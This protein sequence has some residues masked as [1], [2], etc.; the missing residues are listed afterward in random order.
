[1][2]ESPV[3]VVL[4]ELSQPGAQLRDGLQGGLRVIGAGG[5]ARQLDDALHAESDSVR[6]S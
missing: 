5:M 3:H 6:V 2:G 4:L 1:M